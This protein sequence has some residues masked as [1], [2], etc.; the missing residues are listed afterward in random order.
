MLRILSR[1]LG[2]NFDGWSAIAVFGVVVKVG[3]FADSSGGRGQ[4]CSHPS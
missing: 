1:V 3:V 2:D 4:E